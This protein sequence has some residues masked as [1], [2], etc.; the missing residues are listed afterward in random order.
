MKQAQED[1]ADGGYW[2]VKET[3]SRI[4]DFAKALTGGDPDKI[5]EMEKAFEKGYKQA[6]KE[7]GD[8]LPSSSGETYKAV[9]EG[10]SQWRKEPGLEQEA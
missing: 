2:S 1:I 9:K 5:D 4:L 3:S 8:E 7:W 6:T 10:F